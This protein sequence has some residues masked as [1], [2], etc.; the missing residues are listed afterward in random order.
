[1]RSGRAHNVPGDRPIAQN[2]F[3]RRAVNTYVFSQMDGRTQAHF[4]AEIGLGLVFFFSGKPL[5][6]LSCPSGFPLNPPKSVA[7]ASNKRHPPP[8]FLLRTSTWRSFWR[9]F[10][11][12][13]GEVQ[14]SCL[15]PLVYPTALQWFTCVRPKAFSLSVNASAWDSK[16]SSVSTSRGVPRFLVYRLCGSLPFW[17]GDFRSAEA[18]VTG[19]CWCEIGRE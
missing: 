4:F 10:G 14:Y 17:W 12:F 9:G 18:A 5:K 3:S 7:F 11:G 8:V 1:M 13:R 2:V 16:P 15:Q 6:W 19:F